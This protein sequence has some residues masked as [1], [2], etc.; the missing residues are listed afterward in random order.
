MIKLVTT[1]LIGGAVA[2]ALIS[3]AAPASAS[4]PRA[5]TPCTRSEGMKPAWDVNTGKPV[6]CVNTGAS[7]FQWVPDAT[8]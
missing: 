6:I 7:G 5:H 1:A 2:T 3:V 4:T 8:R